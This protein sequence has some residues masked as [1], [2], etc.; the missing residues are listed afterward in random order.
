MLAK[1]RKR[2][3]HVKPVDRGLF[4][5]CW[6]VVEMTPLQSFV[7]DLRRYRDVRAALFNLRA[8]LR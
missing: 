3:V 6:V 7:D 8:V 4:N 5:D 2:H 1:M